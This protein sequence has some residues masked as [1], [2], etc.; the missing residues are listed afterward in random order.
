MS[1]GKEIIAL[2]SDSSTSLE[3]TSFELSSSSDDIV[4]SKGPSKA[5]VS[6]KEPSKELL[7]WYEDATD[8][9]ATFK[10]TT[11][12]DTT[13]DDIEESFFPKSKGKNT[14]RT[15]YPTPTVIF[16]SPIPIM[17]C[18]LG[19]ANF[20]TWDNIVKKFGVRKPGICANKAKGKRKVCSGS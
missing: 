1:K 7:K 5:I 18:V 13:D 10:D 17:R 12:K 2:S 3:S 19:L 16:K 8:E 11:D 14:Q 20:K 15:K 9:D 6:R 4:S